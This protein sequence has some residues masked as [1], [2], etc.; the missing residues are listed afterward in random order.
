M[1]EHTSEDICMLPRMDQ[2]PSD[3]YAIA[4]DFRNYLDYHL[5]RFLGCDY[6]YLYEAMAY[7][8]RDRLMPDWR[9]AAIQTI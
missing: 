8:V 1:A 6:F 5:G 4:S 7:T 2:L 3:P 9:N